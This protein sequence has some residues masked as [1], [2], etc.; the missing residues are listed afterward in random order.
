MFE[1]TEILKRIDIS[2][3]YVEFLSLIIGFYLIFLL[4]V[5][6]HVPFDIIIF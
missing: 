1:D 5:I 2:S 6:G 4:C 3:R